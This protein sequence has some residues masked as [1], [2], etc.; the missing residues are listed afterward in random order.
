[1]LDAS[2]DHDLRTKLLQI[3]EEEV[4]VLLQHKREDCFHYSGQKGS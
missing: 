2:I 3:P 1:M 4:L